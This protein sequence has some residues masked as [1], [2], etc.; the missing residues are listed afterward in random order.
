MK[1]SRSEELHGQCIEGKYS[2][3]DKQELKVS[4]ES[5]KSTVVLSELHREEIA[6]GLS[7]LPLMLLP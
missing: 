5:M 3:Q 4:L 7:H 2:G 6:Q 1:A